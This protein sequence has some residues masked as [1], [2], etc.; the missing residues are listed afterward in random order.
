MMA[1]FVI[2][3]FV[4][5]ILMAG[6]AVGMVRGRPLAG[7]CGGT[8]GDACECSPVKRRKCEQKEAARGIA[9]EDGNHHLDVLPDDSELR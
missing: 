2:T 4:F 9:A 3:L 6:M 7:S 8:A 1:T 5:A